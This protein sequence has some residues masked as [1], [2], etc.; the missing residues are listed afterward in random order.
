MGAGSLCVRDS[1]H[2]NLPEGKAKQREFLISWKVLLLVPLCPSLYTIHFEWIKLSPI[3]NSR[4]AVFKIPNCTGGW[5]SGDTGARG[6]KERLRGFLKPRKGLQGC[7]THL[8]HAAL[9]QDRRSVSS[10]GQRA[11]PHFCEQQGLLALKGRG[12]RFCSA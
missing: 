1:D 10:L 4:E 8:K 7:V 2:C 12:P 6:S 9:P 11:W 3:Q 5:G